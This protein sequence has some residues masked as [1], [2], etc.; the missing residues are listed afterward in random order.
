MNLEPVAVVGASGYSGEELVRLL[1]RHPGVELVALTSRQLAGQTVATV[2]PK[3]AG[4]RYSD[5][6]FI[7]SEVEKIVA[8]G[9][10][11][12]FLA[13][14][15]GVAAEFAKPLVAAGLRVIDLSADFR[16]KDPAVYEEFYG[17]APHA[18]ELSAISVYGLPEIY[19]EQIRTARLVAS[20]GCY[21]TSVIVPLY[22]LLKRRLLK[23]ASIV[24]HSMSGVSGAGRNAKVELLYVECNESVRA[25]SVPKHRHLAEIEQELS[26]AYGETL[27]VSFT[28]HLVPVNRGICTTI[29]AAPAEG[30]GLAE[31]AGALTAAYAD[32]PFIRLLG[33]KG[34]PDTKNVT[35]TNFVD[36]GWRHDPRTGRIVL[37]SAEDNLV[38]GA[39]GQA[40]QSLNVMCGWP[41]TTALL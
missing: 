39:A 14:P 18:P 38:K 16:I 10:K 17:E 36:V 26:T 2:F 40:V 5:L 29:H 32:E 21:P 7:A 12:V 25:Y 35:F 11:F 20:P 28:P 27:N 19:R 3:F 24:I 33:G 4:L 34:T 15:H 30:I 1:T 22:P 37:L 41:E 9:A 31:I 23:P 8:S 6:P 13:L